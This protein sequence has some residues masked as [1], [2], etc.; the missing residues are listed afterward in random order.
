MQNKKGEDSLLQNME[1]GDSSQ[2]YAHSGAGNSPVS[3]AVQEMGGSGA[4]PLPPAQAEPAEARQKPKSDAPDLSYINSD[5]LER[6]AP[7]QAV[8]QAA[9]PGLQKAPSERQ[10]QPSWADVGLD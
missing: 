5:V 3:P 9:A 4:G 8:A 1:M 7:A 6:K 2:W 10:A